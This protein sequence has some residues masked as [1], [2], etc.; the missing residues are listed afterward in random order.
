LIFPF[1]SESFNPSTSL[2]LPT[3]ENPILL[4]IKLQKPRSVCGKKRRLPCAA[5][6][7]V[8]MHER[9]TQLKELIRRA[10]RNH[11]AE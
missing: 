9:K 2:H 11:G 1:S 3:L 4:Q 6:E 7:M 10:K 5:V 8:F